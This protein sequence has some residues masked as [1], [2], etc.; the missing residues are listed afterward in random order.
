MIDISSNQ[1]IFEAEKDIYD[2]ALK[3]SGYKHTVTYK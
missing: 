3:A 1:T 2:T